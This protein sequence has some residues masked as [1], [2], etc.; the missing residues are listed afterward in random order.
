MNEANVQAR[1]MKEIYALRGEHKIERD[2]R[3]DKRDTLFTNCCSRIKKVFHY[4]I[5]EY[6]KL[7]ENG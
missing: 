5:A 7:S 4:S 1:K 6:H 2:N 3:K